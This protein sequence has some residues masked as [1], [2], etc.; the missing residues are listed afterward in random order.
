MKIGFSGSRE[1]MTP[2]QED[3]FRKWLREYT[4]A[5][6][7]YNSLG[8]GCEF[9]HGACVGSDETAVEIAHM[10]FVAEYHAHPSH[11]LATTSQIAMSLSGVR[12]EPKLTLGRNIDIATVCEV[13]AATPDGPER[14]R[15]GTWH[16]IRATLRLKKPVVIFSN[17]GQVEKRLWLP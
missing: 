16:T 2:A 6:P 15:S 4:R 9:H 14:M 1:G 10:E 7:N 13:L 3:A 17:E 8:V 11:L 5:H 12:H